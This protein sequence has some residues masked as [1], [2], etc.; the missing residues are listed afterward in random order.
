[1][2]AEF[3]GL[4]S[5]CQTVGERGGLTFVDDALASNP[6]ATAASVAAFPD[7]ELTVIL[8]GADRGVD[9]RGLVEALVARRPVPGVVLLPPDADRLAAAL[10]KVGTGGPGSPTVVRA[11]DLAEAVDAAVVDD[12]P[13]RRHPVLA[14]SSHPRRRGWV[15]GAQPAIRGGGRFR[16]RPSDPLAPAGSAAR[17]PA[18]DT[19]RSDGNGGIRRWR[20]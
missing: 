10:A 8:G 13:G 9:S 4:P 1:M 5:R 7:R 17:G 6:Y 18:V 14:R 16:R 15:P 11:G 3:E 19:A 20:P 2:V 12:L